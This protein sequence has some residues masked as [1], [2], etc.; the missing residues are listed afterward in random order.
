MPAPAR[1]SSPTPSPAPT[2]PDILTRYTSSP[3]LPRPRATLKKKLPPAQPAAHANPLRVQPIAQ[4]ATRCTIFC[5]KPP[6]RPENARPARCTYKHSPA[7]RAIFGVLHNPPRLPPHSATRV[8]YDTPVTTLRQSAPPH[9]DNARPTRRTD[10][11]PPPRPS[12]QNPNLLP[13]PRLLP[14]PRHRTI[15]P[16]ARG[17][18]MHHAM[19]PAVVPGTS[20][21]G[22]LRPSLCVAGSALTSAAK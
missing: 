2:H 4:C 14:N 13:R 10:P 16:F 18:Q 17:L 3:R 9:P 11:A 5:E 12:Y 15:F 1:P 8:I 19:P 20:Q 7:T 6:S 21:P 22:S